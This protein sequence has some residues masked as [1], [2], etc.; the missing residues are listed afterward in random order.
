MVE[1]G[2]RK[3]TDARASSRPLGA[4][5]RHA[6][7]LQAEA[8][9]HLAEGVM[10]LEGKDWLQS[11]IRFA[12]GAMYRIS[13]YASGEL[14]GQPRRLLFADHKQRKNLDR[15]NHEL[16]GGR[17]C[18][19]E[20]IHRRKDGE[21]YLAH[22]SITPL[23][24]EPGRLA[25]FVSIHRDI[26]LQK[27]AERDLNRYRD[28][29]KKLASELIFA[30]ERERR[31]LAEDLHDSVG[32][33]LFIA[34]IRIAELSPAA[35]A[36]AAAAILEDAGRMMNTMAFELS[37][38]VLRTVGLRPA[39]KSLA[40]DMR[41]R[42]HLLVHIHDDGED[43]TLSERVGMTLFRCVRELLINVAKHAKTDQASLSINKLK[44]EIRL[45]VADEGDGF[46]LSQSRSVDS[47][48]FGLFSVRERLA[49]IG[50]TLKVRSAIGK[51]TSITITA[52]LAA[53]SH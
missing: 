7:D 25:T 5:L 24:R 42:Y 31:R 32:Q 11:T 17:T 18:I 44:R 21:L 10:I 39:L 16:S 3:Q 28:E 29:L 20:L 2:N 22:M 50:G 40:L 43:F 53:A 13:R 46:D 14:I 52:P 4:A 37:P 12:N 30:E 41:Q 9:E 35:D 33:A 8:I 51:G 45:I 27:R 49:A 1:K 34:R 26:T 48:H 23:K 47:G 19:A 15:I 38:P 6:Y 36:R